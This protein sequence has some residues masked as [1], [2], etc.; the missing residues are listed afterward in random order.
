MDQFNKRLRRS[1]KKSKV[2]AVLKP[3]GQQLLEEY[4]E[5]HE[6]SPKMMP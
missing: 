5:Y 4:Q 1:W 3:I 6:E 2:M